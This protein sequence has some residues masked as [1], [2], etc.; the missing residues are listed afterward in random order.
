MCAG[1]QGCAWWVPLQPQEGSQGLLSTRTLPKPKQSFAAGLSCSWISPRLWMYKPSSQSL[2]CSGC[3]SLSFS[4]PGGSPGARDGFSIPF[5][6]SLS[7]DSTGLLGSSW[8]SWDDPKGKGGSPNGA[9]IPRPSWQRLGGKQ[10]L[11][12]ENCH[13]RAAGPAGQR[14]P[15]SRWLCQHISNVFTISSGLKLLSVTSGAVG[16]MS[17]AH[18]AQRW[19]RLWLCSHQGSASTQLCPEPCSEPSTNTAPL[20][21]PPG[22]ARAPDPGEG[23]GAGQGVQQLLSKA[24][25]SLPT[26]SKPEL[27][28]IPGSGAGSAAGLLLISL[29][30]INRLQ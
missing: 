19:A 28:N 22:Q 24:V 21:H 30:D 1:E 2:A 11:Q 3:C 16:R 23:A 7:Q 27:K 6:P 13:S 15:V 20:E 8:H 25:G 29:S 5:P 14:A 4:S 10:D 26:F 9:V 17:P 12:W 18:R